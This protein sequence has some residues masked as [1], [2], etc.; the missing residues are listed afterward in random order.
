MKKLE[1]FPHDCDKT[2]I[3]KEEY[4]KWMHSKEDLRFAIENDG[5]LRFN[6]IHSKR[7]DAINL[8]IKEQG[9]YV[10]LRPKSL[11]KRLLELKDIL[12]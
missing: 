12:R 5:W 9:D 10:W 3:I 7:A 4:K 8:D 1:L 6:I 11:T 2:K